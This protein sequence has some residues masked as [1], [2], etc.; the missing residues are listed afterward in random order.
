MNKRSVFTCKPDTTIDEAL[1]ILVENKITGMPVVDEAGKV[2][3]VVSDYDML[4]LDNISG[5]MEQ[6][7]I[8]PTASMDWEAFHEVQ[9]LILKN[10]GKIVGDVMTP[11]PLVVRPE[12]N[13]EAAAR[14]LLQRKV[15]RLPVVNDSG[16]L[17]GMFSRSD[18]IKA[19][20]ETRQALHAGLQAGK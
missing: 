6:T 4:T 9:K 1:N 15:R 7:G 18:V 3:G 16:K 13:I 14:I 17:V 5:R 2:V 12:T 8:F 20:M 19:A 10:V 11:D